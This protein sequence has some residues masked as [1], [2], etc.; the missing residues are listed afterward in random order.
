MIR[1]R[2]LGGRGFGDEM[3]WDDRRESYDN[4]KICFNHDDFF[5]KL[6]D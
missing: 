1:G 3:R 2:G 6:F 5:K 4:F